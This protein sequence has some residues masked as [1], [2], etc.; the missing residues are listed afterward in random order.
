[1][2]ITTRRPSPFGAEFPNFCDTWMI[3]L[4]TGSV[5]RKK[6][7]KIPV[8]FHKRNR[9]QLLNNRKHEQKLSQEQRKEHLVTITIE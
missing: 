1:M 5:N 7:P 4:E 2:R 8:I 6:H 9:G 3:L